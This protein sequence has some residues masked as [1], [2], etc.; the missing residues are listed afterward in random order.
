MH[1]WASRSE[2]FYSHH[3]STHGITTLLSLHFTRPNFY[4]LTTALFFITTRLLKLKA[5]QESRRNW[6][7][8]VGKIY[9]T[10]TG[11]PSNKCISFQKKQV[12]PKVSQP[13]VFTKCSGSAIR[14]TQDRQ[15]A[16]LQIFS[17]A[18]LTCKQNLQTQT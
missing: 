10:P 16:R 4:C 12:I 1:L 6:G 5:R 13:H 15:S 7:S 11:S 9:T 2:I 14:Q 3:H 18:M 8:V 17:S